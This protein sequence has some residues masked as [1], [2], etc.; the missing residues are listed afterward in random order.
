[1]INS[2]FR[3]KGLFGFKINLRIEVYYIVEQRYY[4]IDEIVLQ[5]KSYQNHFNTDKVLMIFNSNKKEIKITY[6]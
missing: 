2:L 1:M 3:L 5:R 6:Y 4:S